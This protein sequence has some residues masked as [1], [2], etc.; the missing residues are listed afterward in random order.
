M[1][2]PAMLAP[3]RREHYYAIDFGRGLAAL[4]I[5]LWHYQHFFFPLAGVPM[6]IPMERQPLYE[7]FGFFYRHGLEAVQF[8]WLISGFIFM[9]VYDGRVSVKTA[10]FAINRLARLYPLHLLTLVVIAILQIVSTRMV[11]HEQIYADNTPT[12]FAL[13][14]FFAS[15]WLPKSL[16]SFNGP[17]WSVSV[18]V[19]VYAG[20]WLARPALLRTGIVGPARIASG[21]WALRKAGVSDDARILECVQYF[22]AGSTILVLS[23]R[24]VRSAVGLGVLAAIT[25]VAA[26]VSLILRPWNREFL[27]LP[28]VLVGLML[29]MC[30]VEATTHGRRFKAL[31]WVGD[32]TYGTYLWHVPIQIA[33]LI[34]LDAVVGSREVA[35]SPWFLA[36]FIVAV[37]TVARLSFIYFEG[38]A[39][40]WVRRLEVQPQRQLART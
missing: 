11:G 33:V 10:D 26:N 14:V 28:L 31:Q 1:L 37:V 38:P 5:L 23:R 19:L 16:S 8:F 35:L 25:L 21:A 20:F 12:Q 39:R 32:N 15:H 2:V 22:F 24:Y 6:T 17:I 34:F 27:G 7:V 29:A 30:A 40:R 9:A 18:E 36:A 13:N 4:A 3:D